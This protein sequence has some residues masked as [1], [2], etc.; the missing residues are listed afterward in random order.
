MPVSE[1][2]HRG[3]AKKYRARLAGLP[4]HPN[5]RAANKYAEG[6]HHPGLDS[7]KSSD[8]Y[9]TTTQYLQIRRQKAC[10]RET[11]TSSWL[12]LKK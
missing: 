1:K 7:L 8:A 12:I 11:S 2:A 9:G 6:A 3:T 4:L 10:A 5:L